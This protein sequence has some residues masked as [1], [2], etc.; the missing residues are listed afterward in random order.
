LAFDNANGGSS[1]GGDE[2][3]EGAK[4]ANEYDRHVNNVREAEKR[5]GELRGDLDR[6]TGPKTRVPIQ[7]QIDELVRDIRGH[8]K[9]IRQKWPQG[10]PQ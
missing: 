6:A 4:G 7:K 9:E 2:A 3:G 5:V 10:R 8:E 1:S